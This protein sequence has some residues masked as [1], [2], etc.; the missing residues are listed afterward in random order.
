[1]RRFVPILAMLAMAA[2]VSLAASSTRAGE[3]VLVFAAASTRDAMEEAI[4]AF[5]E[6]SI[7]G[8]YAATSALSRQILD[9]APASIFLSANRDW[10]D[11]LDKAGALS[12]REDF[13]RNSLVLAAPSAAP[14]RA[15]INRA[16]DIPAALAGGRLAMAETR[17]VP[18]GIYGR[19]ALTALG[20]WDALESRLAQASNVRSAVLMVERGEAP[21][22]IIYA[23]DVRASANV[24]AVWPI[25]STAH[26]P[27]VY[28]L[29]L[30]KSA[31]QDA[32]AAAFFAFLASPAG[33]RIF[34][35]HGFETD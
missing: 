17:S 29:A 16:T 10:A 6:I 8:V 19:Q 30:V 11:V 35:R 2:T 12:G 7:T 22:G 5:P 20:V 1:M 3:R 23:T 27:I 21:L 25:P 9:G 33:R 15:P 4:R 28:P 18:A 13:L 34:Q 24:S 26:D 32:D 14:P 31:S